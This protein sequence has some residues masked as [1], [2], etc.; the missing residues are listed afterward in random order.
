MRYSNAPCARSSANRGQITGI[1]AIYRYL[2]PRRLEGGWQAHEPS[3][4]LQLLKSYSEAQPVTVTTV[5]IA[6]HTPSITALMSVE[7]TGDTIARMI[8]TETPPMTSRYS[9]ASWARSSR[10]SARAAVLR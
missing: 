10:C 5:L 1:I 4:A 3:A 7:P 9:K 6:L 2:G 8:K